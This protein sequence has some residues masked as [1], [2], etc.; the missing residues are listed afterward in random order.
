MTPTPSPSHNNRT[1]WY[2]YL[3]RTYRRWHRYIGVGLSVLLLIS[4]LTGLLLGWKKDASWIQPP[5]QR[6]SAESLDDWLPLHEIAQ[7]AQ[8]ALADYDSTLAHIGIDRI[9]ARPSKGMAK[10]LFEAGNWEVQIDA[11]TGAALS[12]DKRHSDWIEQ[13]HDGS[14]VSD[15]FKLITMNLLGIGL[16]I[17][18]L[19]GLWLWYGPK[20][21]KR[22]KRK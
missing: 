8:Q 18:A 14:I 10:V 2:V 3:L 22:Q 20:H 13:L 19:S 7:Y 6:G 4:A 16:A 5:S 15:R 9:D 12:I 1:A 21:L 17:L 11:A